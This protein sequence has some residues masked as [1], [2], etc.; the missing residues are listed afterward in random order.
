MN[1]L[2][3]QV[4]DRGSDTVVPSN[5]QNNC[6]YP[7]IMLLRRA[8]GT[9]TEVD[10]NSS[11]CTRT[12]ASSASKTFDWNVHQAAIPRLPL[13]KLEDTLERYLDVISPLCSVAEF[14][15]AKQ[16]AR[17]F[18]KDGNGAKLQSILE[19][20]NIAGG[21]MRTLGT[22]TSHVM[23]FW[24][25]MYLGGRCS[26]PINSNPVILMN[27]LPNREALGQT[28]VAAAITASLV[29][30]FAGMQK[31]QIE[32]DFI[33]KKKTVPSCMEEYGCLFGVTR[34]PEHDIDRLT[35]VDSKHI[36]VIRGADI[37]SVDVIDLNGAVASVQAIKRAM[38]Q[39]RADNTAS[40]SGNNPKTQI[41]A[42]SSQERNLWAGQLKELRANP[43]NAK[44]LDTLD[45]A[46][47]VVALDNANVGDD[48]TKALEWGMH[49]CGTAHRWW[50]KPFTLLVDADGVT[51]VN[52]EH[53]PCDGGTVRRL[54]EDSWHDAAGVPCPYQRPLPS[55]SIVDSVGA[56]NGVKKLDFALSS[57]SAAAIDEAHSKFVS[58]VSVTKYRGLH[59]TDFGMAQIKKWRVS[60]DGYIQM[61][62]QLA[63]KRLHGPSKISVYEV[64]STKRFLRGRTETIRSTTLASAAFVDQV[65]G[66]LGCGTDGLITARKLLNAAADQHRTVVIQ[67]SQGLGAE[68]HLF[69]LRGLSQELGFGA[70]AAIWG[71]TAWAKLN[72]TILSTSNLNGQAVRV[73]GVP[74]ACAE[75][76]GIGYTVRDNDISFAISNFVGNP[77][78]TQCIH[79]P[80]EVNGITLEQTPFTADTNA[81]SFAAEIRRALTDMQ[82][83]AEMPQS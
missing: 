62:Y 51:G 61:A 72:S 64:C 46:L 35:K 44:S 34:I 7:L 81:N 71:D 16:S 60:P 25:K 55:V 37:F 22:A 3:D 21:P 36:A 12:A 18:L 28:G 41:G 67:T 39:I 2:T 53:A 73:L 1:I 10:P 65:D 14:D 8:V 19:E 15:S 56:N 78:I 24:N 77:G 47:F 29:R 48:F 50:D 13:P 32:P 59:F 26:L 54:I 82:T 6:P 83:I 20:R 33:D 45:G 27:D 58:L 66:L 52:F 80:R 43:T 9:G 5:L 40:E 70:D 74:P 79:K 30:W 49:G 4:T 69:S 75:G 11:V 68:R 76:Y 42:L 23:P 57:S 17:A 38:D 31:K 63:Y